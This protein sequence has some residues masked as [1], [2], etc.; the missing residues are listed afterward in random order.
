LKLVRR[1]DKIERLLAPHIEGDENYIII[2]VK[3]GFELT[4]RFDDRF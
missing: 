2:P 1:S 4:E 3:L